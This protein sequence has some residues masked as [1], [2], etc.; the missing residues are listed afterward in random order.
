MLLIHAEPTPRLS[1]VLD[2]FFGERG[3]IPI[4]YRITPHVNEFRSYSGPRIAYGKQPITK[5]ELFI[6]AHGL[7]GEEG[8]APQNPE[9]FVWEDTLALF[10]VK[11]GDL[12]FDVFAA[13]FYLISR[14]EEYGSTARDDH[15]RY[16]PS[17]SILHQHGFLRKPVVNQYVVH[18]R[19]MLE[20]L[21]RRV[22]L[23]P[24]PFTPISTIDIDVAY[25]YRG[26]SLLETIGGLVK[27][28]FMP[29]AGSFIDRIAVLSG[30]K[31]DPY[32][33]YD[34]LAEAHEAV[35]LSPIARRYI[36]SR[37]SS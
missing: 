28:I 14:Y 12:P 29:A 23:P 8:I 26:R 15:G 6:R 35:G 18:L 25:A 32:D 17:A 1:Y 33:T 5:P 34:W 31:A 7:L 30:R 27:S 16:L 36:V 9:P 21:F 13:A 37:S 11:D 22:V 19:R 20:Q 2:V 4:G 10:P 24:L 3:L